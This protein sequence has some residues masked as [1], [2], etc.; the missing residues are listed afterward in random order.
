MCTA[1]NINKNI[2]SDEVTGHFY[3]KNVSKYDS[4]QN[5][6]MNMSKH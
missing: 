3:E 1:A 6:Y 2:D 5:V 4:K